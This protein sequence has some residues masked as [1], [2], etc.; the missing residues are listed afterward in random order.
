M[1]LHTDGSSIVLLSPKGR[2]TWRE[3]GKLISE[4]PSSKAEISDYDRN[5]LMCMTPSGERDFSA[6]LNAAGALAADAIDEDTVAAVILGQ[7]SIYLVRGPVNMD[8]DWPSVIDI[9]AVEP[10]R[11]AWPAGLIW[12]KGDKSLYDMAE[13]HGAGI[14][15]S[16]IPN[17]ECNRYGTAVTSSG[18]GAVLV[19]RPDSRTPDFCLQLPSQE[20][21]ALF[22]CATEAGVLVTIIVDGQDSAYLHIAEDGSI[23]GHRA[24]QTATPALS[25][26]AG[27]L[28]Y[29]DE[30]SSIELLDPKLKTLTSL[31]MPW[32]AIDSAAAID[33]ASFAFADAEHVLRGHVNAKGGLVIVASHEY[34]DH[35]DNKLPGELAAADAKWDPER[36]HGK[37]AVGFAAGIT[38]EAWTGKAG[39]EIELTLYARSTGGKGEGIAV[40]IGGDAMKHCEF[41]AMEVDGVRT[42]VKAD[43]KGNYSAE[44]PHVALV[45]GLAYPLSPKPKNDAQKHAASIFLDDTHIAIKLFGKGKTASGD[46]MSVSVSALRSDSPPLKWMRPL[47]LSE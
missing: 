21:A 14:P 45:Q 40:V 28:I 44:F 33:G 24:A 17:V 31:D 12:K 47:T 36:C 13:Q 35:A 23:L 37:P 10:T 8:G 18:S 41:D 3:S 38:Q 16:F 39:G 11:V 42:E 43:E 5:G 46:L 7:D 19:V 29:D 22:A 25:L 4:A 1:R 34:G 30:K 15:D 32:P 2:L 20:E 6:R 27:F 26:D 9:G